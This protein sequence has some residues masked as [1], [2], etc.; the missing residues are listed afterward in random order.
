MARLV[1]LPCDM[2]VTQHEPARISCV[3]FELYTALPVVEECCY[4][5][6]MT[7]GPAPLV[8]SHTLISV[9]TLVMLVTAQ[10]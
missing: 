5:S 3:A 9:I 7:Y 1:S 4:H 2:L 8:P 6:S 10:T